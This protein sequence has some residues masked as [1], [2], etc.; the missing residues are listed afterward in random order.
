M[1]ALVVCKRAL[2]EIDKL[3]QKNEQFPDALPRAERG[4]LQPN[5]KPTELEL[6][7]TLFLHLVE[8]SSE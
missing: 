8:N 3:A 2:A 4:R 5:R 7:R 1:D 6:A